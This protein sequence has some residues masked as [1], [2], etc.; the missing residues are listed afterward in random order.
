MPIHQ[1][2]FFLE[3]PSTRPHQQRCHARI[4]FVA[5]A[6]RTLVADGALDCVA[7]IELALKVVVPGGRIR[8]LEI[9]HEDV[10][11]GIQRVDDHLAVDRAGDLHAAIE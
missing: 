2:M 3:M 8:I 7:Q 1:E 10:G 9:G 4:E 5:F 6:F 11:A